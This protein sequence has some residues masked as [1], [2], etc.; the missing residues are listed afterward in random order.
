MRL[1]VIGHED[2]VLG[3][4]LAGVEGFSTDDPVAAME[5]LEQARAGGDVGIV[6]ITAGLARRMGRRLE[7]LSGEGGL[8]ILLWVPAPE[9]PLERA[10]IRELVRRALGVAS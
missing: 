3:F 10:S 8:P 2:A 5:R 1:L 4:S 9:E 6:L 7:D